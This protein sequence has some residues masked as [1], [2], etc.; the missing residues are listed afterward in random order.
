MNIIEKVVGYDAREAIKKESNWATERKETYLLKDDVIKP[1][2]IDPH[3]WPIY[4][5]EKLQATRNMLS[6][7]YKMWDSLDLLIDNLPSDKFKS[8][9]SVAAFTIVLNA[10]ETDG[11]QK[12]FMPPVTSP[13]AIDAN[14]T[15]M[16]FDIAD[17]GLI[18][19]ITNYGY[20]QNSASILKKKWRNEL[21]K[22]HLLKRI[23]S[24]YEFKK[25]TCERTVEH[26]SFFLYGVYIVN[27]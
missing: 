24:A 20:E 15:F 13:S 9:Y 19:G 7:D 3:V 11:Y 25:I 23:E 10:G 16:G 8:D 1:L 18:S 6:N 12:Y 14:W 26:N 5:E 17:T 27:N 21:N 2:S 4:S 22:Y